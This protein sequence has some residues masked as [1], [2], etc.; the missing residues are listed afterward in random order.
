[1]LKQKSQQH[2]VKEVSGFK[3][4]D[5]VETIIR[6]GNLLPFLKK[7][8]LMLWNYSDAF[9]FDKLPDCMILAD[10]FLHY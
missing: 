2:Q 1:M 9:H 8:Q 7:S 10:S 6:Q 3:S 4:R 5:M